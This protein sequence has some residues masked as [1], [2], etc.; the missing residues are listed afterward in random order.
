MKALLTLFQVCFPGA[1]TVHCTVQQTNAWYMCACMYID[2]PLNT[3]TGHRSLTR[4]LEAQVA[5]ITT[6][7]KLRESL[8]Q[9]SASLLS[10]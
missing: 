5:L 9:V 6:N 7:Q 4:D 10:N 3:C 8:H 1:H 2:F